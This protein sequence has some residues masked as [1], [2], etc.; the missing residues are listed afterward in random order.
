MES[1]RDV[2]APPSTEVP[3]V[4]AEAVRMMR[5]LSRRGWGHK[6]IAREL[7]V[8]RN[9]VRRYLR[10]APAG[11]RSHESRAALDGGQRAEAVRLLDGQAEGNAVVVAR[12]L[13]EA[14][15]KASV[16]TVQR[17]VATHRRDKRAA[18]AATV[19]FETGPGEQMQIDYGEKRVV[20]AGQ[21]VKVLLF[22][23]VLSYSRRIFVRASL[24]QRQD[25][26]REGL[27][28]AFR[29]FGG[30]ARRLL[31]DNAGALV[32]GRVA[33]TGKAQ[34]H[35][36]FAAFCRDQGVDVQ[37]CHPYRA[38][39]KGKTESGVKYVKR[40]AIA[41]RPFSSMAALEAHLAVWCTEADERIH[42]TTHEP[43]RLRFERD[44]KGALKALP[45]PSVA[46]RQRRL[47]RRVATD[48]LVDVDT[49]RYSVPHR[50][51]GRDVEVLIDEDAVRVFH[52]GAEVARHRRGRE[53]HER[54]TE[55]SHY[56]GLRRGPRT[57]ASTTD[58]PATTTSNFGRSL[59]DYAAAV[60]GGDR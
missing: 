54:I 46:V 5:E 31:I 12:L 8:A 49:I 45:S 27:A 23:A 43:P 13:R 11:E 3:M 59:E 36:D 26:W 25:D 15:A 58:E 4:E 7:G 55:A 19:R 16:R 35:P 6:R 30:V 17:A 37:V 21:L 1:E 20:V 56:E 10:G 24:A 33:A 41:G 57:V 39:T 53:P 29:H 9:T 60:G 42:G 48:C 50:L 34:L 44:E 22:V 14:G 51:V 28:S 2:V 32:L 38:R 18:D 47:K 40:N 52:G